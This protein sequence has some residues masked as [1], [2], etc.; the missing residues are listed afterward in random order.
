MLVLVAC[1]T[2]Q[3]WYWSEFYPNA[4]IQ[5]LSFII[6]SGNKYVLLKEYPT[7]V[8]V[9]KPNPANKHA[10]QINNTNHWFI[11]MFPIVCWHLHH[12][13]AYR[14][15]PRTTPMHDGKWDAGGEMHDGRYDTGGEN[16]ICCIVYHWSASSAATVD[17]LTLLQWIVLTFFIL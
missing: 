17:P 6:V 10:A 8:F 2:W 3:N 12:L 1:V 11:D 4:F 14:W 7:Y 15:S 16:L 13:T 5:I 9:P